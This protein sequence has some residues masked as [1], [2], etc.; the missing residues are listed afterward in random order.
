[1]LCCGRYVGSMWLGPVLCTWLGGHA[2][3]GAVTCCAVVAQAL[4]PLA[5]CHA[6]W[7]GAVRVLVGAFEGPF[8][9]CT[10]FLVGRWFTE[11]E[12]SRAQ[13]VLTIGARIVKTTH[14]RTPCTAGTSGPA[15]YE[16]HRGR[17]LAK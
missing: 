7:A 13:L 10:A 8:Y 9:P 4:G 17:R 11:S 15:A 3:L 16:S 6:G 2:A 14:A 1:V 12:Y 5:H